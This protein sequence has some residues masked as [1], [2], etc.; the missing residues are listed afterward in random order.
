MSIFCKIASLYFPQYDQVQFI[1]LFIYLFNVAKMVI[2]HE[3]IAIFGYKQVVQLKNC[4]NPLILWLF[5][6]F[7]YEKLAIYI[8]NLTKNSF[9]KI[10][11]KCCC[12]SKL[13]EI[14]HKKKHQLNTQ[15]NHLIIMTIFVQQHALEK[16]CHFAIVV[17]I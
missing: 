8:L 12:S 6:I 14:G 13:I 4:L 2:I 3:K 11:C 10:L 7:Y 9:K 5:I 1:Y 16:N 15:Y 17:C